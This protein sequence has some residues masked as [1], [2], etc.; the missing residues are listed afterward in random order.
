M[1][2][3]ETQFCLGF[4]GFVLVIVMTAFSYHAGK[5]VGWRLALNDPL[6][7]VEQY[8]EDPS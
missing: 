4:V 5:G 1:S 2:T 6:C 8:E 7:H 3:G